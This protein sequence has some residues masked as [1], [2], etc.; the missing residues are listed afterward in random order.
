MASRW[1]GR[2]VSALANSQ[3]SGVSTHRF[4]QSSRTDTSLESR[5]TS[6]SEA[7]VFSAVP[8]VA[9]HNG[10]GQH[11]YPSLQIKVLPLQCPDLAHAQPQA[12]CI[13]DHHLNVVRKLCEK[14]LILLDRK[15]NFLAN[16]FRHALDFD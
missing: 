15:H 13:H 11:Q 7:P 14:S 3:A 4:C 12:H 9:A 8:D 6:S 5:N 2:F 10:S 16:T 1:T